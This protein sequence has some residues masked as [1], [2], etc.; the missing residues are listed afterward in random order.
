M[1]EFPKVLSFIRWFTKGD[2]G[3]RMIS[4]REKVRLVDIAAIPN[5]PVC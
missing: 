1:S 2:M 4:G 3:E 5:Q